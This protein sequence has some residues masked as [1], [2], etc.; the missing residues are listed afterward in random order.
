M[1]GL[2]QVP[3]VRVGSDGVGPGRAMG[4]GRAMREDGSGVARCGCV[5]AACCVAARCVACTHAADH[6]DA[7]HRA[8]VQGGSGLDGTGVRVVHSGGG[9]SC[10]WGFGLG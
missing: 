10:G 4:A 8:G 3:G 7:L 1:R 9:G 6:V 2:Q 5:G